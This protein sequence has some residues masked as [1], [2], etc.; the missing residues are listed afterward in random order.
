[1]FNTHRS[2]IIFIPHPEL[3]RWRKHRYITAIK[4]SNASIKCRLAITIEQR[5]EC[6]FSAKKLLGRGET[7]II[8]R[9][10]FHV[11]SSS[12]YIKQRVGDQALGNPSILLVH[13]SAQKRSRRSVSF[14][15]KG[16]KTETRGAKNG[17]EKGPV[18][19]TV[20]T[21]SRPTRKE[22]VNGTPYKQLRSVTTNSRKAR[23]RNAYA[24]AS[25]QN[26][27]QRKCHVGLKERFVAP[28]NF[29]I[30]WS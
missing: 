3:I 11:D 29:D 23:M 20:A 17:T 18:G 5:S 22:C 19:Y 9:V 8:V 26:P 30:K 7:D 6:I 13:V 10:R 21:R 16:R 28:S 24:L 4:S 25:L 27:K 15:R 2:I 14:S 1:M 12:T